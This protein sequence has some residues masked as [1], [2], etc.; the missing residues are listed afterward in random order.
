VTRFEGIGG[1]L[2]DDFANGSAAGESD[3]VDAGVSNERG[4]SGFAKSV[5]DVDYAGRQA[6]LLQNSLRIREQ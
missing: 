2:D 1:G 5:D 4:A 6:S 3:F